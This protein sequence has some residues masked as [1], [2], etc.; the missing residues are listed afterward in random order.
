MNDVNQLW[1][2]E[3]ARQ[4]RARNRQT[5]LA[6]LFIFL[7]GACFGFLILWTVSR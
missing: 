2:K 5:L 7:L 1:R 3:M 4:Q 6:V